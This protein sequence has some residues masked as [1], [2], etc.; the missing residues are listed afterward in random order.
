MKEKENLLMERLL[1]DLDE[2]KIYICS[3]VELN[4]VCKI[5]L[6]VCHQIT[7]IHWP[8]L[9]RGVIN[10]EA[11]KEAALPIFSDMLTLSQ[12]GGADYTQ[13]LAFVITTSYCCLDN[14]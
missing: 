1:F 9:Y 7:I 2:T 6:I 3:A 11:D 4:S 14:L 12:S 5:G 13:P 10:S 8:T